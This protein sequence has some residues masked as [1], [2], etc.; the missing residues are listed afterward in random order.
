MMRMGLA[1]AQATGESWQGVVTLL[2]LL[3]VFGYIGWRRGLV[4]E[5]IVF[6]A[7]LFGQLIRSSD[8]GPGLVDTINRTWAL[9]K[10]GISSGFSP[11][12]MMQR[13][14]QLTQMKPLIPPE[15]QEAFLFLMFIGIIFLGYYMGRYVSSS[16][17][18]PIS[19]LM[20]MINGYLIGS[21]VLPLL[22]RQ[23]PTALPGQKLSEAQ[24]KQAQEFMHQGIQQLS[25]VL[26]IE[27]AY[28]VLLI[29]G[30]LILW[31]AWELR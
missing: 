9:F 4:R 20:G 12:K 23:L 27:P 10:L 21:L 1:Q 6:F 31:A 26:G 8:M 2:V 18:S 14:N 25:Q 15:R 24:R 17:P 7:I 13:A 30:L 28:L 5:L 3:L 11:D 16:H 19:M 29:V 22:P